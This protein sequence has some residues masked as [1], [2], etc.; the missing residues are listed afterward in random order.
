ME[1]QLNASVGSPHPECGRGEIFLAYCNLGGFNQI[2]LTSKRFGR[3]VLDDAGTD[4]TKEAQTGP[5]GT[6][7]FPVFVSAQEQQRQY[8]QN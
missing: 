3:T 6:A 2:E 5:I 1:L 7:I 4:V 8:R